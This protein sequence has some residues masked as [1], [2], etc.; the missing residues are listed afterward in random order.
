MA[1][2]FI[3]CRSSDAITKKEITNTLYMDILKS[4][5]SYGCQVNILSWEGFRE[6]DNGFDIA[7]ELSKDSINDLICI[8]I[9]SAANIIDE[10]YFKLDLGII[11]LVVYSDLSEKN[12]WQDEIIDIIEEKITVYDEPSKMTTGKLNFCKII[13]PVIGKSVCCQ[14]EL[15]YWANQEICKR[16]VYSRRKI[17]ELGLRVF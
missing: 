15:S 14:S 5:T 3:E 4:I 8:D 17:S 10:V 9:F 12:N 7:F 16:M 13:D 1:G 11:E 6:S 2:S